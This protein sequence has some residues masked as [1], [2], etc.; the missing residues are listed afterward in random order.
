M[1]ICNIPKEQLLKYLGSIQQLAGIKSYTYNSGKEN[2]I[3][4]FM[5]NNGSGMEFEVLADRGMDIGLTRFKG[6]P[7]SFFSKNG[8]VSP[9]LHEDTEQGFFRSFIPGMLTT[10]GITSMGT[11]CID[12]GIPLGVH[13]RQ[14]NTPAEDVSIYQEWENN[15]FVMKLRG[16][17]AET[18]FFGAHMVLTRE[19]T[20]HMGEN[21]IRIHDIVENKGYE[22]TPI[23]MLYHINFGFPLLSESAVLYTSENTIITPRTERA[24]K[25]IDKCYVF[26]APKHRYKEQV[27][28]HTYPESSSRNAVA[29][30]YNQD[31]SIGGFVRFK[32][33][34]LPYLVEW[35]QM[36][37]GDYALGLEPG[38]WCCEGR[39][40]ARKRKELKLLAPSECMEFDIEIG[41]SDGLTEFE[42][43]MRTTLDKKG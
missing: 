38:T 8:M 23:M 6:M 35:K 13:G 33:D 27:F 15:C 29:G 16:K 22:D 41:I 32:K 19:I 9:Y 37:E 36:G 10:C 39:A 5:V 43:C 1:N 14:S 42:T 34:T 3:K 4:A 18:Q 11:A 7:I 2:G 25:G 21:L 28:Y 20:C 12:E 31:L 24:A 26:E 17:I 40:E 30:I